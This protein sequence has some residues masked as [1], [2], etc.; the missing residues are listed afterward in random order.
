MPHPMTLPTPP[1]ESAAVRGVR[2][3]AIRDLLAVT[4]RPGVLSLAGGLPATELIPGLRIAEAAAR[5]MGSSDA[6]QYTTSRG[7]TRCREAVARVEAV[8]P[9][10][11]LLT[12]GSQQALSLLAQSLLDPADVVVVDD[13]VYVG[14]LQAF[15]SVRAH[16]EALPITN[17]GTNIA[18]L[19]K[20]LESGVRPRIVHTV[21]NFHN[22]SGVTSTAATR[23]A[24]A[25]LAQR[26]GFWIID[27]DP[28]GRLRFDDT[29]HT[30]ISGHT[31]V[32]GH[33]PIPGER[34]IR[35]GS[36]SKTLAPALR[37]GWLNASPAIVS[38]VERLKQC[39]DLCGSALNQLMVAELLSDNVWFEGHIDTVTSEYATR[40]AALTSAL[41]DAFGAD[42]E[43]VAPTGGMFC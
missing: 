16:V 7:A 23:E 12:H 34:V 25:N 39:A 5:V 22:P 9:S 33:T 21:S 13:P 6:L 43:Y 19:V 18:A 31:T 1:P 32:S 2:G 11:I 24:L 29:V 26:Y 14:A 36:A 35:L 41:D 28:Y 4:E 38:L 3:S 30:T 17:E 8:D 10:Q 27:D 40:S 37:V 20:L 42:V 15:Q